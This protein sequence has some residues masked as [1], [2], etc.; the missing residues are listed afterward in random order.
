M[1]A[2][3]ILGAIFV[4]SF[5]VIIWPRKKQENAVDPQAEFNAAKELLAKPRVDAETGE[6]YAYKI[7]RIPADLPQAMT[8]AK[9]IDPI[10]RKAVR[11]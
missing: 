5:V 9:I 11:S 6:G 1:H 8:P 3:W 10:Q 7:T 2:E 4:V